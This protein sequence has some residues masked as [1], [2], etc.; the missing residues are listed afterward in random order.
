VRAV[1][2]RWGMTNEGP[3]RGRENKIIAVEFTLRSP[4]GEQQEIEMFACSH[5]IRSAEYGPN[6]GYNEF[7][8]IFTL[9]TS[10]GDQQVRGWVRL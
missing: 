8:A 10:N 9:H 6:V 1:I 7:E 5:T 3:D 4:H 2:P